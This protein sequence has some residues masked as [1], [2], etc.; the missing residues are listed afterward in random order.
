MVVYIKKNLSMSFFNKMYL[1][2]KCIRDEEYG[3][4]VNAAL[5]TIRGFF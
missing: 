1:L 5:G 3:H 2:S 4:S